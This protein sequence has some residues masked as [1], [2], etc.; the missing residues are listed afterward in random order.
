MT[1]WVNQVLIGEH[2]GILVLLAVFSLGL[3]STFTSC[4]NPAILAGLAGYSGIIG[5]TAKRKMVFYNALFFLTGSVIAMAIIGGLTGSLSQV[6][7]ASVGRYWKIAAGI[8]IIA[9]G[10]FSLDLLPFSIPEIKLTN[11][12][13]GS[14]F[15]GAVLFGLALG[16]ASAACGTCCN[17]FF[18]LVLSAAFLK[19][20]MVWGIIMLSVF[21]FG[22]G[23]PL[24]A[25]VVGIG[26]GFGR[27]SA[28]LI[29]YMKYIRTAMGILMLA[30][31]FYMLFSL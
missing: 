30:I 23:L 25:A 24:A 13:A 11:R 4:C 27:L 17:P 14:G 19:G 28:W 10:L 3:A 9:F 2:T 20:S 31:G 1:E 21:G 26:L 16:G 8:I 18:P 7:V 6:L 29:K 22:Y 15:I 12:S 5:T